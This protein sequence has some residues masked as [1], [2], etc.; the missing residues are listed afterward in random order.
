MPGVQTVAV[1]LAVPAG[2]RHEAEREH[3]LAHLFEHM[4]FKGTATRSARQIAEAIED[5]GGDLNAW[6]SRETVSY[7]HLTLPTKA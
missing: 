5:V 7:T 6:T 3:G 2:A 1:A 4:L